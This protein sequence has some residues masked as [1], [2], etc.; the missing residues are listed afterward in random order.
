MPS[1]Y[2]AVGVEPTYELAESI[3]KSV[4]NNLKDVIDYLNIA[5]NSTGYA[6]YSLEYLGH[7]HIT[8]FNVNKSEI[9]SAV[10][11]IIEHFPDILILRNNSVLVKDIAKHQLNA[12][13]LLIAEYYVLLLNEYE[14]RVYKY[15]R[16]LKKQQDRQRNKLLL[17]LLVP[18]IT[19]IYI[20]LVGD[21]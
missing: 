1:Y 18:F 16:Y 17:V 2:D 21:Q 14:E 7:K 6:E 10:P 12:D 11:I 8:R 13:D 5:P 3:I 9:N 19:V 4:I 15:Q 20:L